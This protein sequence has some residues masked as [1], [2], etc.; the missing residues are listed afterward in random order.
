MA[1]AESFLDRVARAAS[2]RLKLIIPVALVLTAVVAF[3]WWY[4]GGRESTDDAQIDGHIT[5]VSASVGG[6]IVAVHVSDNQPVTAGTV[7]AEIDP[8]DYQV[9]V[10]RAAAELASAQA[11]AEAA[12]MG[13]PIANTEATSGVTTAQGGVEQAQAGISTSEHEIASARARLASAEAT[14]REREAEAARTRRDVDRLKALIA[15]EEVSQQ[16][17]DAAVSAAEASQAA[18]EAARALVAEAETAIGVAEARA[19]Q[20]R[21]SASQ[22]QASLRTAQ[23]APQ[24][25]QATRAQASV[26][27]ARVKQAEAVLASARLNLEHATVRAMTNGVISRKTV[28]VGQTVAPGQALMALVDLDHLWVTANFKETQLREMK[29]G[30]Q[31]RVSVDA[32]GGREFRGSVDSVAAATGAR[33]SLL[34]PDNATGNY[35]KVV[36]R[37]PVKIVLDQG[38]DPDHRLRPGMSVSPTVLLRD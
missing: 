36:Q 33:F 24:Q 20:A 31:V 38:Q 27:A 9:A 5:Q 16:Q 34:P 19:R 17:Y 4:Y 25:I 15:K 22:A 2:T 13:V 1:A 29:P 14:V 30:Q 7:L 11:S 32:L 35:V 37:V 23:T 8:R 18:A 10:D 21:A 28:E 12:Q 3:A 6:R 26:A